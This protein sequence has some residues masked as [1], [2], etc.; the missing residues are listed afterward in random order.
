MSSERPA[1]T[2][3]WRRLA[4]RIVALIG[5]TAFVTFW[6]WALFF[7]SKE[8]VNRIDDREWAERAEAICVEADTRRLELADYRSIVGDGDAVGDLI[9]ERADIVDQATDILESMIGDVVAVEPID[10]KGRAIVPKWETEYRSY[11]EA[12]RLYARELRSTRENLAFYEPGVDGI[13]VSERLETFAGDND[14]ASCAP[15]RDLTR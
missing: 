11:L 4:V 1:P 3:M 15:P 14:M 8:A 9:A 2:P 5:A 10:P 12:R 7:A 13:P 6:G